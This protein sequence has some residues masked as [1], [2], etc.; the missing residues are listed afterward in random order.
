M[1][2]HLTLLRRGTEEL[3]ERLRA[4]DVIKVGTFGASEVKLGRFESRD[5]PE[6]KRA[7][8]NGL[9]RGQGSPVWRAVITGIE[10]FG[11]S[12]ADERRVVL[13]VSD[14]LNGD[15]VV[16]NSI[17]DTDAIKA[18]ERA[19]VMIYCIGL[20]PFLPLSADPKPYAGLADVAAETGGGYVE[21]RAGV[22]LTSGVATIAGVADELHAQ[23]LLG[24]EPPRHDGKVHRIDVRVAAAGMK[25]RAR[26]NYV[27][28]AK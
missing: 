12:T 11:P 1:T 6:L 13:L 7:L 17:T 23:Y 28:P 27:A 15:P 8:P 16:R 25:A 20:T 26:R 19:G 4:D 2:Q 9:L 22:A 10:S 24:F 18:A 21:V 5:S 3:L 14:G